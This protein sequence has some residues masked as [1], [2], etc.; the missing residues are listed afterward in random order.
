MDD[1]QYPADQLP[2]FYTRPYRGDH[3]R[4]P[5]CGEV[6]RPVETRTHSKLADR[7]RFTLRALT[8][9]ARSRPRTIT[10]LRYPSTS[11][12]TSTV[13]P[14][15]PRGSTMWHTP[16]APVEMS[17]DCAKLL[18]RITD[19]L[20]SGKAEWARETL[21]GIQSNLKR[22]RITTEKMTRA[23]ENISRACHRS[24][25]DDDRLP[26]ERGRGSRRYEGFNRDRDR[27]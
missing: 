13:P 22:M 24:K 7:V 23:V 15:S 8:K 21:E 9:G 17:E 11:T 5:I 19:L 20:D 2:D 10:R 27:F 12:G 14:Q 1:L 18:D 16:P 3:G 26:S 6:P 25:D 4:C